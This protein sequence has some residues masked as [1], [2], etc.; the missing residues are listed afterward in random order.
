MPGER[1]SRRLRGYKC[2]RMPTR[3]AGEKAVSEVEVAQVRHFVTSGSRWTLQLDFVSLQSVKN[4]YDPQKKKFLSLRIPFSI[5]CC[6]VPKTN[7]TCIPWKPPVN[8]GMFQPDW[9]QCNKLVHLFHHPQLFTFWYTGC[10][11][12]LFCAVFS[13]IFFCI[14][15]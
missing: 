12:Y 14:Q 11:F 13:T 9:L 4:R 3:G 15:S 10:F 2:F 7:R 1:V 8:F 6:Q 5:K